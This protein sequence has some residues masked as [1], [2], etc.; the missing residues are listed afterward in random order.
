M[1]INLGHIHGFH[2]SKSKLKYVEFKFSKETK[3]ICQR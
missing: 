1:E 3:I 2:P